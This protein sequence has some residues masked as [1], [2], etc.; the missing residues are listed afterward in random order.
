MKKNTCS[1]EV[2]KVFVIPATKRSVRHGGQIR[3]VK[4]IR[5]GA[6]CRVSTENESQKTS[7]SNQVRYYRD[8]ISKK[9]GWILVEVYADEATSGTNR[10]GRVNF[11]RMMDDARMG[12]L[13]YI[14]TKSISRFARNTVD[15]LDCVRLLCDMTPPVGVYFEKENIDTLDVKGELF[16][17]I[18]SALAQEESRSI[19][20]NIRWTFQKN[21]K[22]GIPHI[23]L[24]RMLGYDKGE[25]GEWIIN[26][27]QAEIIRIIFTRY[28]NGSSSRQI[29]E[30]LNSL[31]KTT[32]NGK[33]WGSSGVLG[34]LH[35]EKYVGDLEMQKTVT[36]NFLT[37]R[38]YKNDGEAPKYY[39]IDHH[40]GII[41]RETWDRVQHILKDK[42]TKSYK[43]KKERRV[44]TPSPFKNILCGGDFGGGVCGERFVRMTYTKIIK[45][46]TDE[47]SLAA[48][49]I[50]SK[51]YVEYYSFS[52]PI[53]R[54]KRKI[55]ESRSSCS[56]ENFLEYAA[57]QTVMEMFYR[58]KEDYIINNENSEISR[59]FKKAYNENHVFSDTDSGE[60]FIFDAHTDDTDGKYTPFNEIPTAEQSFDGF[61]GRLLALPNTNNAGQKLNVRGTISADLS[62]PYDYLSFE[63]GLY[64]DFIDSGY[65]FGDRL[66]LNT[67]F[68]F[69]LTAYGINRKL[70]DFIGFR[71]CNKYGE[72]IIID[73]EWQ[74]GSNSI[75]YKRKPKTPKNNKPSDK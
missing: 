37:H 32:V 29:A 38:S 41:D 23:N 12:K 60:F 55:N 17:T 74:I 62:A 13:D 43:T 16:L 4:N 14:V 69:T 36:R 54:C 20:D 73:N 61:V 58:L 15:A 47:R 57:E 59:L 45:G 72:P 30:E 75:Q 46:Y 51:S 25:N 35:N 65:I 7:Y 11:N 9:D 67:R 44:I 26:E 10:T 63:K 8:F 70:E 48:E 52:Y 49:G 42:I 3:E 66:E 27:E 71:K 22:A 68:G 39:V 1:A 53:W 19:S 2:P 40:D 21:F 64:A 56:S 33:K 18:L 31:G 28:L 24:K 50:G 34:I 5:V 6:Y